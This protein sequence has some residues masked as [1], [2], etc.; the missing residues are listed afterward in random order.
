MN[1]GTIECSG[2]ISCV[3]GEMNGGT[4]TIKLTGTGTNTYTWSA[5]KFPHIEVDY[6]VGG[7][8]SPYTPVPGTP[9]DPSN[10][11]DLT[12]KNFTLTS[13][14][15]TA[16]SGTQTIR[17]TNN[18]GHETAFQIDDGTFTH[19]SGRVKLSVHDNDDDSRNKY[20]TINSPITFYDLDFDG[21]N[22]Y[23]TTHRIYYVVQG[24]DT[25]SVANDLSFLGPYDVTCNGGTIECGGNLACTST[26]M[27]AGTLAIILNGTGDQTITHTDGDWPAGAWTVTNTDG[28]VIQATNVTLGGA[29]TTNE[30]TKWCQ[31]TYDLAVT[32]TVTNDG[33]ITK[34]SGSSPT[35]GSGNAVEIGPCVITSG[36]DDVV[37]LTRNATSGPAG[38]ISAKRSIGISGNLVM[39]R[40]LRKMIG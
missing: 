25:A 19:N 36:G 27:R 14:A 7:S 31:E 13:G 16:P 15:F 20:V 3:H 24:T 26:E 30:N 4:G 17:G 21:G 11:T 9:L 38:Q 2:D 29:L 18:G 33:T 32:G 10:T 28:H 37:L 5:G 23:G 22:Q 1:T 6:G 12:T 35:I 39:R 40:R 34:E 8:I